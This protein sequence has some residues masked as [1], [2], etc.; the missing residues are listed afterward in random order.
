MITSFKKSFKKN[1]QDDIKGG[2]ELITPGLISGWVAC[3]STKLNYVTLLCGDSKVASAKISIKRNDVLQ[4]LGYGEISGFEILLKKKFQK[5]TKTDQ[6]FTVVVFQNE[7]ISDQKFELKLFKDPTTTPEVISYNINSES[8]GKHAV[9]DGFLDERFLVGWAN[10]SNDSDIKL[11]LHCSNLLPIPIPCN[12]SRPD[13][14]R[15]NF[16]NACGFKFDLCQLDEAYYNKELTISYS[17]DS[18][19]PISF[20]KNVNFQRDK[21]EFKDPFSVPNEELNNFF[22]LNSLLNLIKKDNEIINYQEI[23]DVIRFCGTSRE[24]MFAWFLFK[25]FLPRHNKT[26]KYLQKISSKSFLIDYEINSMAQSNKEST[27]HSLEERMLNL[28]EIH[29]SVEH[30]SKEISKLISELF[31]SNDNNI[32]QNISDQLGIE[33]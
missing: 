2:I 20:F 8:I 19:E 7:D 25:K 10:G 4:K 21:E 27:L 28:M 30:E 33:N 5:L 3:K 11:W 12:I 17:R 6:K 1:F 18:I 23:Y 14:S 9:F 13:L 16:A 22:L 31:S 32:K 26:K 29:L 15:G 24:D